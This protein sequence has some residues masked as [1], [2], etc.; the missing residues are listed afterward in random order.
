MSGIEILKED[1]QQCESS[2]LIDNISETLSS[3]SRSFTTIE[4][5]DSSIRPELIDSMNTTV[6]NIQV[7]NSFMLNMINR[8]LDYS[9]AS[10]GM[11]LVP[12]YETI[13]LQELL[14]IPIDCMRNIQEKVDIELSYYDEK[15]CSHLI[16][17]GQWF[18]EN[19]LCLLSNAVKY[20]NDGK[21]EISVRLVPL[22]ESNQSMGCNESGSSLLVEVQDTGIGLSEEAMAKLFQPFKQSQKLAGGTGLG[23]FSLAKRLEALQGSYGVKKRSDQIQGSSFWFSFPYRP[24]QVTSTSHA[25][26]AFSPRSSNLIPQ[27]E[28]CI[29]KSTLTIDEDD[30]DNFRVLL[31]EDTPSM[32]KLIKKLLEKQGYRVDVAENGLVCFNM[33]QESIDELTGKS[34]YDV[35]L[36]DLQMPVMDGLEATRRIR[37]YE[38]TLPSMSYDT[39]NQL[40]IGVS[41]NSDQETI[42]I[43]KEAGVSDFMCKPFTVKTFTDV[44]M[45]GITN[46]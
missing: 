5:C 24:D 33:F 39:S 4:S 7:T 45:K 38:R 13:D 14:Q 40:I 46:N 36:M 8:C 15:I 6:N 19:L 25:P 18:Q 43:A 23:L 11:K 32:T 30:A 3:T 17:D 2:F 16:T 26:S 35:I 21:V 42:D 1:L 10:S 20:S 37:E 28:R 12:K 44:V 41:A 27:L 9:K 31:A 34:S 29:S 22:N